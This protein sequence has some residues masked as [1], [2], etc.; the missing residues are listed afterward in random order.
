MYDHFKNL[1]VICASYSRSNNHPWLI[2]A[3]EFLFILA[4]SKRNVSFI[5]VPEVLK[6]G[7]W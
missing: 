1:N 2:M 3:P 6:I 7:I 5:E 4:I